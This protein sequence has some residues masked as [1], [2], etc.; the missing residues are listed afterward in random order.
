MINKI[1]KTLMMMSIGILLTIT[2]T[3]AAVLNES[4]IIGFENLN[5]E[6]KDRIRTGIELIPQEILDLHKTKGGKIVFKDEV[7][8]ENGNN[9]SGLYWLSGPDE[10]DIWINAG[11]TDQCNTS[12]H[13]EG[14]TLCHELGHFIHDVWKP[15]MSDH[16]KEILQSRYE[17]WNQ[18]TDVCYDTDETFAFLYSEYAFN[19]RLTD[20]ELQLIKSAEESVIR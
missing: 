14:R 12:Y 3:Y 1:R 20:D 8:D 15:N 10:M 7:L 11:I 6:T 16:D 17:Y 9:V 5:G 2:P 18:Y 19:E 13:S 4:N